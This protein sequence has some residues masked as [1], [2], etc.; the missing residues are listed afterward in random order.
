MLD[1]RF[2]WLCLLQHETAQ[3]CIH[4]DARQVS[5]G[6]TWSGFRWF[7]RLWVGVNKADAP[8]G[9]VPPA[10]DRCTAGS[11]PQNGSA[12]HRSR[13]CLPMRPGRCS[14]IIVHF[15]GPWMATSLRV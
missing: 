15:W 14:A 9:C 8:I 12:A 4:Y 5:R 2:R 3:V 11:K 13:H 6:H 7:C 10:P 1:V